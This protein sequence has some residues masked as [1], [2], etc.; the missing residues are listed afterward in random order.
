MHRS[1]SCIQLVLKSL[2]IALFLSA[3]WGFAADG[4][5]QRTFE[6]KY[7]VVRLLGVERTDGRHLAAQARGAKDGLTFLFFVGRRPMVEG[8]FTLNE[9]RDFRID[10][11]SYRE[12]STT[13]IGRPVEPTTTI[14]DIPDFA[15]EFPQFAADLPTGYRMAVTMVA[16]I[17]GSEIDSNAPGQVVV[18]VGWGGRQER[19]TFLFRVPPKQP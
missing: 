6:G 16:R 11:K 18:D 2:A 7:S 13:A 19:F 15:R 4:K 9:L 14:D 3:S 5:S 12:T 10:G 8:L 1:I 17:G